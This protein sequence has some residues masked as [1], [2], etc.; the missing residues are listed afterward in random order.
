MGWE[1]GGAGVPTALVLGLWEEQKAWDS[2]EHF[3][4]EIVEQGKVQTLVSKLGKTSLRR[5]GWLWGLLL[6]RCR[7]FQ[8]LSEQNLDFPGIGNPNWSSFGSAV[9]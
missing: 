4:S 2:E 5:T 8:I 7:A 3:P 6:A 9:P 1:S